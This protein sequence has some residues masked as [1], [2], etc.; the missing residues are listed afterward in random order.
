MPD[1]RD[2]LARYEPDPE[3][4]GG[5]APQP[6]ADLTTSGSVGGTPD[7]EAPEPPPPN[8]P[9]KAPAEEPP[10]ESDEE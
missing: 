2:H 1:E 10:A 3:K 6:E 5:V 8:E 7:P 9:E 4:T